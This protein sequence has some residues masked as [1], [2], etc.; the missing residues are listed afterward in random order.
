M[1]DCTDLHYIENN[2]LTSAYCNIF[3]MG[4]FIALLILHV[5]WMFTWMICLEPSYRKP[6]GLS[7][8]P[9]QYP[10]H[11]QPLHQ[12]HPQQE[13]PLLKKTIHNNIKKC[14]KQKDVKGANKVP[15]SIH[16]IT[17]NI[18][19]LGISLK[20]DDFDKHT[21]NLSNHEKTVRYKFLTVS[22][23]QKTKHNII[24][25]NSYLRKSWNNQC[26]VIDNMSEILWRES[27]LQ[28]NYLLSRI[29]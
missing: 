29:K 6:Q 28:K 9:K 23:V 5:L 21:I 12:V 13:N 16:S 3:R 11:Q 14:V 25:S 24:I 20:H 19:K 17:P 22:Y 27:V 18:Q 1:C 7:Q 4:W 15:M 8:I 10:Y 2:F 26:L